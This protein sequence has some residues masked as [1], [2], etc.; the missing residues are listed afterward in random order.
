MR[1]EF[2]SEIDSVLR[3]HARRGGASS[4][5]WDAVA[6]P[7]ISN[8]AQ[9]G[10]HL[11][12]DEIAA[13]GEDALPAAARSRYSAHL[14][15]CDDC[16][17]SVTQVAFA[18]GVAD[19]INE[20]ESA[21]AAAAYAARSPSAETKSPSD[22]TQ[23]PSWRERLSSL[24]APRA[25]RYAMPVVALFALGAVVFVAMRGTLR[26]GASDMERRGGGAEQRAAAPAAPE[27]H[28]ADVKPQQQPGAPAEMQTGDTGTAAGVAPA[29]EKSEDAVAGGE[30][31]KLRA[32]VV[33]GADQSAPGGA[34]GA[35]VAQTGVVQ[36]PRAEP[37]PPPAAGNYVTAAQPSPA[38]PAAASAAPR[39]MILRDGVLVETPPATP[40]PAEAEMS[41]RAREEA[42][43]GTRDEAPAT[44][45]H[46]PQR[47]SLGRTAE[48]SSSSGAMKDDRAASRPARGPAKNEANRNGPD[49]AKAKR[50]EDREQQA[51]QQRAETRAVGG[52]RFRR[53]GNA[54]IDTAYRSGQATVTMRRDS[55]QY[56]SLVADEP[57][58]GQI[59]RALGGEVVIVWKGRAYRVKQ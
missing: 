43:A 12:A 6:R 54:W 21:A 53:E 44:K 49:E 42:R 58:I 18:A 28:H 35:G 55:E 13:F 45:R 39:A 31:A 52:R 27:A 15:D 30:A 36:L 14:A 17:R 25:W 20:R 29:N 16:R 19:R 1:P 26:E 9:S 33:E 46:G 5:A 32:K 7:S 51:Q 34:A 24:F 47:G 50:G 38:P 59:S 8:E 40:A 37:A 10:S 22:A 56:R 4:S 2:D 41:A 3:G 23:S 57:E 11:D 48:M